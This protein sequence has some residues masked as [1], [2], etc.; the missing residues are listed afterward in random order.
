[1]AHSNIWAFY[2]TN[3]LLKFVTMENG[4]KELEGKLNYEL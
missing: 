4:K 3:E 2:F 1:L